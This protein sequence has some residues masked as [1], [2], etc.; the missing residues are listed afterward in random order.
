LL[1]VNGFA[2][3]KEMRCDLA[4]HAGGE[5]CFRR[6]VCGSVVLVEMGDCSN[7]RYPYLQRSLLALSLE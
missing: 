2:I 1:L 6:H 4:C 7:W 5:C 3:R